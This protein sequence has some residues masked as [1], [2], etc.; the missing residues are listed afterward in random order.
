LLSPVVRWLHR[1]LGLPGG[2]AACLVVL[3]LLA[4]VGAGFYSLSDP[5][6]RWM[7]DLPVAASELEW[8]L[9]SLRQSVDQLRDAVAKLQTIAKDATGNAEA[10]PS[11]VTLEGPDLTQLFWGGTL[12][13]GAGLVIA[14]ALL[15]F[16]LASN[17]DMLRQGVAVIPQLREKKQ[18]VEIV[19]EVERDVSF[20]L[21]TITLI[22][23]GLG[24]AIGAAMFV[25]DMPNPVLWGV[26]AAVLNY[27][28]LLGALVGVAIVALVA[29]LTFDGFL[30][31]VLPPACYL[32]L[33]TLEGQVVTP[34]LLARRLSLNPV[35]VFLSLI[36][37]TWLWGIAGALLAVP[38]L[39]TFKICCD[40]IDPM[41]P[42]GTLLARE[43]SPG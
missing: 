7:R 26:I 14:T 28:P 40:H 23:I 38:L 41:K 1:R 29:M 10:E 4:S 39:A 32:L 3:T 9:N 31:M 8:K 43:N 15:F 2:V 42:V 21:L 18:L 24:V 12:S 13:V 16:L 27:I 22:N 25:L 36:L 34:A 20:Y 17:D 11:S 6:A 33:T 30:A 19:R 5:A 35:V 37:W